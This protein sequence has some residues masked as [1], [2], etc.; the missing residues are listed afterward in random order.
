M[1]DFE[2]ETHFENYDFG[3]KRYALWY[4]KVPKILFVANKIPVNEKQPL[5]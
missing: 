1:N 4:L 2:K 3:K 5:S